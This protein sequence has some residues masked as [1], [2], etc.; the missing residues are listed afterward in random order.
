MT[1]NLKH[2]VAFEFLLRCELSGMVVDGT[3]F[4]RDFHVYGLSA[5]CS[6]DEQKKRNSGKEEEKELKTVNEGT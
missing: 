1:C 4:W 6:P 5:R 2:R 3:W